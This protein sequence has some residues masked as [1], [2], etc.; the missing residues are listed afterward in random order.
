MTLY[1]IDRL[2][3]L[4]A[5]V[6]CFAVMVVGWNMRG[7]AGVFPLISGGL[8]LLACGWLALTCRGE[9]ARREDGEQPTPF[10]RQRMGLW[11]LGLLALLALMEPLGTFIVVPLFLLFTLKVLARLSWLAAVMLACGFTLILY[12]VFA[13]LLAVPLP[14]GLLAS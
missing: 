5:A 7:D 4:V 3:T 6:A 1:R 10:D 9:A 14:M 12:L 2:V 13:Y 11:C 8:G